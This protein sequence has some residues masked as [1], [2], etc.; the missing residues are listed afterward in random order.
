VEFRNPFDFWSVVGFA[1]FLAAIIMLGR[2]VGET[3]GPTGALAGA[4][5]VG[6]ADVDAITVSMAHLAPGTLDPAPATLAILAAVASNT[7]AKGAIGAVIGG[8]WFA[9]DLAVM[10]S[11]CLIAAGAVLWLTFAFLA[12]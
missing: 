12:Q 11:A 1:L 7:A 3:F 10:T 6:L 9:S 5:V 4:I 2:A 8:G